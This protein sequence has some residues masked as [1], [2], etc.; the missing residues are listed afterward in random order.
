MP[1]SV[2][3]MSKSCAYLWFEIS[4]NIPETMEFR[5]G[6]EHFGDIE[7]RM[8]L[9][10]YPRVVQERSKVPTRNVFHC[11]E[12]I[13]WVLKSVQQLDQPRALCCREDVSLDKDMSCFIHL[14]Q[15]ALPHLLQSAHFAR[16]L[17]SRQEH[18][19]ISSLTNLSNNVELVH[20]QL[21]PSF[22]QQ[23]TLSTQI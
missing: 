19:A 23:Y 10:Q 14:D 13:F 6:N 9:F 17:L 7:S 22:A 20:F 5:H 16:V 4:M 2:R 8:F 15:R 3:N 11:Q 1:L 21:C 18:F 12:D